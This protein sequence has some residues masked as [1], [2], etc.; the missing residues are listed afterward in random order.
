MTLLSC[1]NLLAAAEVVPPEILNSLTPE[2]IKNPLFKKWLKE[3]DFT[4]DLLNYK[5][6]PP[7]PVVRQDAN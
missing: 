5:Y 4:M 1:S 3:N 2:Q 6:E 7:H